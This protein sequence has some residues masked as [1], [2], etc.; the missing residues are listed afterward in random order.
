MFRVAICDD[1]PVICSE[2][3]NIIFDYRKYVA[4][5]IDIDV[6]SSGE[7]LYEHIKNGNYFDLIFLDIELYELSGIELG[8][9]IREE[10]KNEITHIVYIS[11][12]ESYAMKLFKTN[13]LDFLVKPFKSEE[14]ISVVVKG[15]ERLN[16]LSYIFKYKQ[17]HNSNGKE[18]KDI[19]YFA[20]DNRQVKMVT[21]TGEEVF[22][23]MLSDIHLQLG[24]YKF[25][26]C[27]KSYLVN[28]HH[29]LVPH[30][31]ELIMSNKDVLPIS[32]PKRSDVKKILL[33]YEK[34]EL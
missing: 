2:I 16:K 3:E 11:A 8:K 13:P 21:V 34:D 15:M 10:M 22:Y 18:I 9:M 25:F 23:G 30:H 4:E 28:Y 12:K 5:K 19:I 14:I 1:E 20:S 7:E 24:S 31:N 29:V 27:H 32:Q 26:F 6:F 17:G 33:K